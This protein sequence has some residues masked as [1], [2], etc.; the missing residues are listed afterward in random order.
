[1][2]LNFEY[3]VLQLFKCLLCF[4]DVFFC[5]NKFSDFKCNASETDY[6]IYLNQSPQLLHIFEHQ[7]A[8]FLNYQVWITFMDFVWKWFINVILAIIVH[9]I[10][11]FI[12]FNSNKLFTIILR[13][14]LWYR[15][16]VQLARLLED[17]TI[18][19]K[20][21]YDI[22]K[23]CKIKK[24]RAIDLHEP[25]SGG[26]YGMASKPS[27]KLNSLCPMSLSQTQTLTWS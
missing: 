19:V 4:F 23:K 8:V 3:S 16:G 25:I 26:N 7:P 14:R 9:D 22:C 10:D 18:L 5:H 21:A 17:N 11:E 20:F 2:F 24:R 13:Y 15:K 12:F 27:W 1:M 6:I